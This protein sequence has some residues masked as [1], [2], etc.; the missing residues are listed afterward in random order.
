MAN[1][2]ESTAVP[3]NFSPAQAAAA[4]VVNAWSQAVATDQATSVL[5]TD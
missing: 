1:G 3:L 5:R 2:V 4:A